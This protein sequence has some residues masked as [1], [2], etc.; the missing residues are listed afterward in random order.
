ML[1]PTRLHRY[2]NYPHQNISEDVELEKYIE[3]A[4]TDPTVSTLMRIART[5]EVPV[6]DLF[7]FQLDKQDHS[8]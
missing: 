3:T 8:K 4:V 1:K 6:S 7:D 2:N 5:L